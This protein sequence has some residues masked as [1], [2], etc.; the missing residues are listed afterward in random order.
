MTTGAV[1]GEGIYASKHYPTAKHY[2]RP[3][4]RNFKQAFRFP[5]H[6]PMNQT[7][8]VEGNKKL[9]MLNSVSLTMIPMLVVEVV[10][11]PEYYKKPDG[12]IL[13]ITDQRDIMIRY[14]LVLADYCGRPAGR[15]DPKTHTKL[16]KKMS[17]LAFYKAIPV[18][19]HQR[20]KKAIQE[21]EQEERKA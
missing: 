21:S 1:H 7:A 12:S 9:A 3:F 6:K 8:M 5:V 18:N 13:V 11:R 20:A 17:D 15:L 2:S 4:T 16:E 10:N 14:Y 19:W